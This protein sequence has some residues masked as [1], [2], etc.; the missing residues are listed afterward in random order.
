MPTRINATTARAMLLGS[1]HG[2]KAATV[3]RVSGYAVPRRFM[4]KSRGGYKSNISF[5]VTVTLAITPL[6][7]DDIC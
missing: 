6:L 2:G 5:A 4:Y 1:E 7:F 3:Y